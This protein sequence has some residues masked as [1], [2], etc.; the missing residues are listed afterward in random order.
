MNKDPL[1]AANLLTDLSLEQVVWAALH[2]DFSHRFVWEEIQEG[3]IPS[4]D[5]AGKIIE[6]RLLKG[7]R[8]HFGPL[9][10][11]GITVACGYIPHSAV[12]QLRTHRI[13][14]SFD[15][16]S[17]RYTSKGLTE[18]YTSI[19]EANSED[20]KQEALER[21][22]YFRPVGEYC[23]REG[24]K[25][26]YSEGA[27][28]EDMATAVDLLGK[29][30]HRVVHQRFAPEHSRGLLPFEL[31]QHFVISVNPRSL[32]HLADLRLKPNAQLECQWA[33]DL[34]WSAA[35]PVAPGVFRWY[36]NKRLGKARLAP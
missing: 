25:Y 15:C 23:D 33:V 4:P 12:Q 24:N 27:R 32:M 14:I 3:E 22:I 5:H 13:G 11:G 29:Y 20:A 34:I 35:N 30:H 10:H 2:Q 19:L 16:Q 21:V 31:R 18:A 26:F 17:F 8:G 9:E 1:M 6:S 36:E 28:R 7:G